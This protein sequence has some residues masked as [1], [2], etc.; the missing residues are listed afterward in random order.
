MHHASF[1]IG[2]ASCI[3]HL[4]KCIRF[5]TWSQYIIYYKIIFKIDYDNMDHDA[6]CMMHDLWCM[7]HHG[8]SLRC[9]M[10]VYKVTTLPYLH[11]TDWSHSCLT[12]ET[13]VQKTLEIT[14]YWKHIFFSKPFLDFRSSVFTMTAT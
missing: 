12:L 14:K 6:W 4:S 7:M 13:W 2:E 11:W 3:M 9:I 5:C 1:F 8:A 10:G